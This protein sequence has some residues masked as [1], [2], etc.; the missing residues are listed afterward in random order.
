MGI[1]RSCQPDHR[2]IF[3]RHKAVRL[4]LAALCACVLPLA[5][6]AEPAPELGN[7]ALFYGTELALDE[8][9]AFDTVV[10]DPQRLSRA[11]LPTTPHTRWFA[12]L[13]LRDLGES[14]MDA[15]RLVDQ[16]LKPL[17]AQGYQGILLDDQAQ[18]GK[19]QSAA[20]QR[21]STLISAVSE[22][23]P[24][25]PV[26]LRNH[27]ELARQHAPQ[28]AGWVVDSLFHQQHG[29][30][31]FVPRVPA[32]EHSALLQAV[33][34]VQQTGLPVIAVDYCPAGDRDCRREL[35]QRLL[36]TGVLPYVTNPA[37]DSIGHGRIEV[38]PRR[39]L[40]AQTIEPGQ[41]LDKT[42][43]VLHLALPINYLGYDIEYL[44]INGPL[45]TN[46]GNDRYAGIVVVGNGIVNDPLAWQEWLL[47][48]LS[49]G[50]RAAIFND[51]G[52]D[53]NMQNGP[54]LDLEYVAEQR[55][56]FK[57]KPET[58]Y[59]D[60]MMGFEVAISPDIRDAL[61]IRTGSNSRSLLRLKSAGFVY[62]AAAITPWG[63]YVVDNNTVV[64]LSGVNQERWGVNPLEF[65]RQALRLPQMP[66]P[67][68]TTEN[69]R[70]LFFTHIDGDGFLS[71]GEFAGAT[72]RF[73]SQILLD[74]VL[75]RYPLPMSMS[76]IEAELTELNSQARPQLEAIARRMFALPNIE[77]ASHTYTH[78][79]FWSHLHPQTGE[80]LPAEQLGDWYTPGQDALIVPGYEF[81]IDRE[82]AGSID[83]INRELAPP[84]K[85]VRT[86]FWTGDAIPPVAGLQRAA[87]AGVLNINAGQTIITRANNSWT[88]IGPYGVAK[89]SSDGEYQVYAAMMNEN[90]YTE[91]WTGPFYGFRR[92]VETFELT[93]KPH[94]FKPINIY[95]HTYSASKAASLKAL[96]ELFEYAL[97]QDVLPIYPSEYIQRV[98]DWRHMV[99]AR[100]GE[101]WHVRGG[102]HLRQLRWPGQQ[103]PDMGSAQ[104]ISGYLP[105]TDGT[106]I[107]MDGSAAAFAMTEQQTSDLPR[108]SQAAGFVRNLHRQGRSL[109]FEFGGYYKPVVRLASAA[110]CQVRVNGQPAPAVLRANQLE[111][112]VSGKADQQ[113][114]YH[115]IEVHCD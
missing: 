83:Y 70:R 56:S 31:G 26:L 12:R 50:L 65:L 114:R 40:L 46:I 18:A 36:D 72:E 79:Y 86:I 11:Q 2:L 39:I 77:L 93:D 9:R 101:R 15:D 89:G 19:E 8:L 115:Q 106:Y 58:L 63:G 87:A 43:G 68:V 33:A 54:A 32:S 59:Q 34:S 85:Q 29:H 71:R 44:D 45:P 49:D 66:V 111:F 104:G 16:Q 105:G 51:F 73:A 92:A 84:G 53:L 13:S 96:H 35:A 76:I 52:F 41:P 37:T 5:A 82:I 42:F 69:G 100:E 60:P 94:R 23:Y 109:A 1:F 81:D 17:L 3:A 78:P 6:Q 7:P 21:L 98:L 47:D 10:L 107:H 27:P 28:L 25:L 90:V 24:Q 97:N 22:A 113:V 102:E 64:Y 95:Y 110:Q 61:G 75:S 20:S 88:K 55:V 91:D 4:M 67:D 48:R 57:R 80:K 30:T 14:R 112:A 38:M 108:I 99:V 74:E 103:V 62:D